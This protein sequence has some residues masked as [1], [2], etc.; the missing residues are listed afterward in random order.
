M[1][2]QRHESVTHW[3]HQLAADDDSAAQAKLWNR[4]F[5][6]L[7]ALARTRLSG[8]AQRDAEQ[9]AAATAR[10]SSD[11]AI[12]QSPFTGSQAQI[13]ERVRGLLLILSQHPDYH[14]R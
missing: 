14:V 8:A 3:L 9:R 10:Q 1:D 6:R 11:G 7:A 2:S 5:A 12:V 13:D 4:Y